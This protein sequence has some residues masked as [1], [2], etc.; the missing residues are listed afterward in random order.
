MAKISAPKKR[1]ILTDSQYSTTDWKHAVSHSGINRHS[2]SRLALF[3]FNHGSNVW[4]GYLIVDCGTVYLFS[5]CSEVANINSLIGLIGQF[6]AARHRFD[7]KPLI[8]NLIIMS[9]TDWWTPLYCRLQAQLDWSV[10]EA[11]C[12]WVCIL[13][14][15][16]LCMRAIRCNPPPH[17]HTHTQQKPRNKRHS[18][19]RMACLPDFFLSRRNGTDKLQV[20]KRTLLGQTWASISNIIKDFYE[21]TLNVPTFAYQ[22]RRNTFERWTLEILS[23][24]SAC[25]SL[26]QAAGVES[27]RAGC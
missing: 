11:C 8:N 4:T 25:R 16:S 21:D 9:I 22:N 7:Q 20:Y 1:K 13:P 2:Y 18:P 19:R 26:L 24:A 10:I 14:H 27:D 5:F 15:V 12:Q 17:T 23:P 3:T 6:F